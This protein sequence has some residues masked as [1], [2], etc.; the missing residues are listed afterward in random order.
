MR[1]ITKKIAAMGAAVMMA[2]S[3][4]NVSASAIDW[5][6]TNVNGLKKQ[7]VS[8]MANGKNDYKMKCNSMKGKAFKPTVSHYAY[9][10]EYDS[11]IEMDVA[12]RCGNTPSFSSTVSRDISYSP[13]KPTKFKT[14]YAYF[15]LDDGTATTDEVYF[16]GKVYPNT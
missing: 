9:F 10:M 7:K 12:R 8:F 13:Y 5:K 2:V 15:I 4:M 16:K 1:K 3:M 6:V 11:D 14:V